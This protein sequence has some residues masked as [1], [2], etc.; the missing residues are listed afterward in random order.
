MTTAIYSEDFELLKR[1]RQSLIE[2]G[3]EDYETNEIVS[4]FETFMNT[5]HMYIQN[6]S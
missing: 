3:F 1:M 5:P 4:S 2:A 6:G